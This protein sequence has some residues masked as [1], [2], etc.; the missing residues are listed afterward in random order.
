MLSLALD[1]RP[2]SL[3]RTRLALAL[4]SGPPTQ[5]ATLLTRVSLPRRAQILEGLELGFAAVRTVTPALSIT[6]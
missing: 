3:L 6:M 2:R 4:D 5:P 1:S